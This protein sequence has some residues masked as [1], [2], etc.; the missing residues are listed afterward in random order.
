MSELTG[1]LASRLPAFLVPSHF[2]R[3]ES[4]PLTANGKID[5]SA[6]PD[7]GRQERRIDQEYVAPQTEA[8]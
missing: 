1:H 6:L 2:V 4:S 8:E 5:R 3:L 7:P